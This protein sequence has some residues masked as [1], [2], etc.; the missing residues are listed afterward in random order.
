MQKYGLVLADI[1]SAMYV[2]GTSASQDANNSI[3]Q[4]WNMDDILASNGLTALTAA[5]FEVVNLTPIVTGLSASSGA[6]NSTILVNGQ[7]FSGAAGQIS[8]FFGSVVSNSVTVL[9]DTQLSVLVPSGI[10]TVNVTVQSGV[11]ETDNNSDPGAMSTR[12]FSVTERRQRVQRI[13]SPL[14][15]AQAGRNGAAR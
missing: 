10:G 14:P 8:V 11:N 9:S 6:A 4:T 12:P 3:A 5:D 15:A 13:S 7:N 2:T 1:G